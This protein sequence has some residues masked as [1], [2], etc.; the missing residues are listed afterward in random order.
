MNKKFFFLWKA[1]HKRRTGCSSAKQPPA[2]AAP[3]SIGYEIYEIPP[4]TLTT[5]VNVRF[6]GRLRDI[7][8]LY[9][10]DWPPPGRGAA[11]NLVQFDHLLRKR[12]LRVGG[13]LRHLAR[14]ED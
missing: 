4:E 8:K 6:A 14:Q 7:D 3:S 10:S 5:L 2:N 12:F 11:G 9:R 1:S 13:S